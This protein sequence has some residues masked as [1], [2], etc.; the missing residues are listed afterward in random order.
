MTDVISDPL[1]LAQYICQ[2]LSENQAVDYL[3]AIDGLDKQAWKEAKPLLEGVDKTA[4]HTKEG[5]IRDICVYFQNYEV[6]DRFLVAN[7]SLLPGL[8]RPCLQLASYIE[9]S[10]QGATSHFTRMSE[11][12]S[13]A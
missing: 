13:E 4:R 9:S 3:V 1:G 2:H 8:Q 7:L 12:Q 6:E 10:I 11:L 5:L